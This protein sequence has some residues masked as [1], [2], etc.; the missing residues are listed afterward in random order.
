[1]TSPALV[2]SIEKWTVQAF[3]LLTQSLLR[4]DVSS[5]EFKLGVFDEGLVVVVVAVL[6]CGVADYAIQGGSEILKF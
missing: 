6:S 5:R 1:M 3:S 2:N 4:R